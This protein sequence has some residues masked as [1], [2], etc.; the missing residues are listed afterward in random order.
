[1]AEVLG[2]EDGL[3]ALCEVAA[4]GCSDAKELAV[5]V[6]RN[7]LLIPNS[8]AARTAQN[9]EVFLE[10]LA[11]L[12]SGS[13]TAG[14][15]EAASE[16]VRVMVE[17]HPEGTEDVSGGGVMEAVVMAVMSEDAE[18]RARVAAALALRALLSDAH[19]CARVAECEGHNILLEVASGA[20]GCPAS[21]A[22][23]VMEALVI[24]IQQPGLLSE[25]KC[26]SD[27]DALRALIG[28]LSPSEEGGRA[29]TG[30]AAPAARLLV[31]LLVLP[32]VQA[33]WVDLDTAAVAVRL[34]SRDNPV[35][36][37]ERQ[38][39]VTLLAA[40]VQW[41]S[42]GLNHT[43]QV[44]ALDTLIDATCCEGESP[45]VGHD[46][47]SLLLKLAQD[48]AGVRNRLLS[49]SGAIQKMLRVLGRAAEDSRDGGSSHAIAV[50]RV[51]ACLASEADAAVEL[52]GGGGA[53]GILSSMLSCATLRED[54]LALLSTLLAHPEAAS[55]LRGG[56]CYLTL[57]QMA[58]DTSGG[59]LRTR[60]GATLSLIV[61]TF[62]HL[63]S[64]TTN[65]TP[66]FVF[67]HLSCMSQCRRMH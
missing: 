41:T 48:S 35:T 56:A 44:E 26:F 30:V 49:S 17:T 46:A 60:A 9:D 5:G 22:C 50:S 54:G 15:S 19:V 66:T 32:E 51:L 14:C 33:A 6:I 28:M 10:A 65:H 23:A 2:D 57:H 21:V 64:A 52:V 47:A 45:M 42:E 4:R 29:G 16:C 8:R 27:T 61:S 63:P 3:H 59:S 11:S 62:S 25:H 31:E 1:V 18:E 67:L 12:I 39:A 34:L 24:L 20:Q 53:D 36:E 38:A 7:L 55:A 13:A 37:A 40:T 43:L 58:S